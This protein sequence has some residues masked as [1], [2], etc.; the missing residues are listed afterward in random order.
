MDAAAANLVLVVVFE[1]GGSC[2][3]RRLTLI[4]RQ[5]VMGIQSRP[6]RRNSPTDDTDNDAHQDRA[7]A[8][9]EKKER[10]RTNWEAERGD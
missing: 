4:P 10:K 8:E 5:G 2:L 3:D 1:R 6:P 9:R 7:G